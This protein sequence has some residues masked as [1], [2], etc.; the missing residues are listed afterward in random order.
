MGHH[1]HDEHTPVVPA[2]T[3]R[4]LL[5][6]VVPFV[7]ATLVGL[8]LLWPSGEEVRV[9]GASRPTT[10]RIAATAIEV[11]S[12][13]CEQPGQEA[14][15]CS[16]VDARLE[17]G[18]FSGE[19]VPLTVAEGPNGRHVRVGDSIIV[20]WNP[21]MPESGYFFVDFERGSA[22]LWLFVI[23]AAVVIALSRWRGLTALIGTGIGVLIL[24]AFIIPSILEGNSPL[25]VSIVGGSAVMLLALYLAHGFNVRTTT[26]VLG[27]LASLLVTG[28]L[29]LIFV[30][31]ARFTG[32]S[33]EEA[34]F[35]Q[36]SAQ[37]INLQG[38]ILGG[39]IIGTL[40]VLD[41]V[42]V[43]QAS[44]VWEI[45]AADPEMGT[46][47]LYRSALRIGRAHIASTVNTLVLAYAGAALP[48]LIVFNLADRPVGE[49][50]TGEIVAEEIVRTLVGSIGLVASVPI[51]TGLAA[52]VATSAGTTRSPRPRREK[53][54][55]AEAKIPRAE[56]EWREGF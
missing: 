22:L 47:P 34:V 51:T 26:A 8:A 14:F 43:T 37:Q 40:G 5:V 27:V 55:E 2:R 10:E 44:A 50:I 28:I 19:V 46:V 24:V 6:A 33:T 38:L 16:I 36:V 11:D 48:L 30:E 7:I 4:L 23:F 13:P 15:T 12:E 18:E 3:K 20:G 21:G 56:A 49:I 25:A 39:I 35:L 32:F 31:A 9:E 53:K 29:A 42:T 45:H 52:I 41:D 17:E 1:H 54:K